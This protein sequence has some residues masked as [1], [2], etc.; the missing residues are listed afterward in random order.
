MQHCI[1]IMLLVCDIIGGGVDYDSG[2]Y[3]MIIPAKEESGSISVS[4]NDD[5]ILEQNEYFRLTVNL[6]S[7]PGRVITT[8]RNGVDVIIADNDGK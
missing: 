5:N 6:S 3:T 7:L 8:S 1:I 2:P 4:I